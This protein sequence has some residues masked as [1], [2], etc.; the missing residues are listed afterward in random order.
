M[1]DTNRHEHLKIKIC[2]SGSAEMSGLPPH[3][4][5]SAK[6]IGAAIANRGGVTMSGAT[7]GY[8]FWA[9]KG[10]K[11]AG[12]VS[13]GLSPAQNE[14]EHVEG[15]KLPLDYMDLIIYTGF[16]Y[17]G[18]DLLLVR[19]SDAVITGPGRIGTFHEFMVAYETGMPMGVLESDDWD[20]DDIL[21][22]ILAKSTR[23]SEHIIFDKDPE[24][25]VE[26][27]FEMVKRAKINDTYRKK[28]Y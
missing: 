25:L 8:P 27:I 9:A 11:E 28:V 20:T 23:P 17:P 19:S 6:I 26:R 16:G 1:I 21:K 15:Y 7:T 12:G 5:E 2:V 18:R 10:A 22:E 4:H 24:K 13:I 14:R 3:V